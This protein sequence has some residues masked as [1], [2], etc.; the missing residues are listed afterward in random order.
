M[1]S[2]NRN[3]VI[4]IIN[5]AAER[6]LGIKTEK[7]LH[8]PYQE[9]LRPEHLALVQEL[10]TELKESE[11]GVVERQLEINVKSRSLTLLITTTVINDDEG[12]WAWCW[13][14]RI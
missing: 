2:V 5:R 7:V 13:F 6:M 9:V 10:L 8:R 1:I 3:D 14:S 12:H 11:N 4:T